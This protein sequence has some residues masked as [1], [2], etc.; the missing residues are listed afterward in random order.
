MQPHQERVVAEQKEL[1]EKISKLD[2]FTVGD[3]FNRL[4]DLEKERLV[5]QLKYMKLY[6]DVLIER[7]KAF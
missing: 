1:Q 4:D 3:I 7:I 6:S 5:R 2:Q